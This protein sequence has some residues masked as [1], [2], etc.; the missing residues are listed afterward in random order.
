MRLGGLEAADNSFGFLCSNVRATGRFAVEMSS[1]QDYLK[2]AVSRT[3]E[4][5]GVL[6]TIR[7]HLRAAVFTALDEQERASG[8]HLENPRIQS[9]QQTEEG[10]LLAFLI[11]DYLEFYDLDYTLSVFAPEAGLAS[12]PSAS[13]P[14]RD[15]LAA[16]LGLSSTNAG[17]LLLEVLTARI[18]GGI[19][20][21]A[22]SSG[23]ATGTPTSSGDSVNAEGAPASL[24]AA[25]TSGP[26]T[27]ETDDS[28]STSS[29]TST[30]KKPD[31]PGLR[32]KSPLASLRVS[33]LRPAEHHSDVPDERD[34]SGPSTSPAAESNASRRGRSLQQR[35]PSA[36]SSSA[37]FGSLSP[38]GGT[39]NPGL[40]A[41]SS[42]AGSSVSSLP[43]K[44]PL[45][46]AANAPVAPL[47]GILGRKPAKLPLP[48]LAGGGL[49]RRSPLGSPSGSVEGLSQRGGGLAS[50]T[51][52]VDS[53]ASDDERRLKEVEQ[54]LRKMELD[55]STGMLK[56]MSTSENEDQGD[57]SAAEAV[58]SSPP[59][60]QGREVPQGLDGGEAVFGGSPGGDDEDD[61][62]GDDFEDEDEDHLEIS[63]EVLSVGGS[64]SFD[65]SSDFLASPRA[66]RSG[67]QDRSIGNRSGRGSE[68]VSLSVS[69][70]DSVDH[71][72]DSH[73]LD[74]YDFVVRL[75]CQNGNRIQGQ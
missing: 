1:S 68:G 8:V 58:P 48:P 57:Q 67:R 26:E 17:P 11:R 53:N 45:A 19:S 66:D 23:S 59:N 30:P 39:N 3:L 42:P 34:E 5:K 27:T 6:G 72:V 65:E 12:V 75:S 62:D 29:P 70:L 14:G 55:D 35:S 15:H 51:S 18:S 33:P 4:A 9:I 73:A 49:M 7:A 40:D 61:Y 28:G 47:G 46:A 25:V 63:E 38:A 37:S 41:V 24:P 71:S 64:Q 31:L 74:D 10:R 22:S 43:D 44:N 16:Q 32:E 13:Y 69:V 36:R 20:A 60:L 52:S 2:E 50:L 21:S 54:D 56:R